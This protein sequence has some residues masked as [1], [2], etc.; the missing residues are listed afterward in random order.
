MDHQDATAALNEEFLFSGRNADRPLYLSL[1]NEARERVGLALHVDPDL[2]EAEI[3]RSV[4]KG[5]RHV[6]DP[7]ENLARDAF[8]DEAGSGERPPSYT[9][10][11]FAQCH[12]AALMAGDGDYGSSNYYDRLAQALDFPADRLRFHG[13]SM[14]SFWGMFNAWLARNDYEFGRPTARPFNSNKYINYAQTQAIIRAGDRQNFHDMFER[15]G[16]SGPDEIEAHELHQYVQGWIR[17]SASND[18]L[19]AAWGVPELRDRFC[20]IVRAELGEWARGRPDK[21]T[22]V[23]AS[24]RLS[25]VAEIVR[26]FPRPV[27]RLRI[28]RPG[29]AE[30]LQLRSELAAGGAAYEGVLSNDIYGGFTTLSPSPFASVPGLLEAGL[31]LVRQGNADGGLVWRPRLL[32]P[33][34]RSADGPYWAEVSR[35]ALGQPHMV[36]AK[37]KRSLLDKVNAHLA[38]TSTGEARV[39]TG[40]NL[41]GV[42]T[43][44]VLYDNVTV[45]KP[46][47]GE[48]DADL[49]PLVP[50]GEEAGISVTGGLRLSRGIWHTHAPPMISYYRGDAPSALL[51][52]RM[53]YG[54]GEGELLLSAAKDGP[55]VSLAGPRLRDQGDGEYL[56]RIDPPRKGAGDVSI[57]LRSAERPRALDRQGRDRVVHASIPTARCLEDDEAARIVEGAV[58]RFDPAVDLT[59]FLARSEAGFPPLGEVDDSRGREPELAANVGEGTTCVARGYHV[60]WCETLPPGL[61][62]STP[63]EMRCTGCEL[64]VLTKKRGQKSRNEPRNSHPVVVHKWKPKE[65][66]LEGAIDH[67]TLLDALCFLGAGPI[68]RVESLLAGA[69]DEA[70]RV[71]S[72]I[73]SYSALGFVD[74]ELDP[75]T[76]RAARFC[77]PPPAASMVSEASAVLSGFRSTSMI[78]RVRALVAPAGG[79]LTVEEAFDQ[80]RIVGITGL[81]YQ[82]LADTLADVT[83][84]LGRPI[85][86]VRD[87]SENL[88]KACVELGG[89]GD[90]M[91]EGSFPLA[92]AYEVF[93]CAAARWG[94]CDDSTRVGGYRSKKWGARYFFRS[95]GG[96]AYMGPNQVV[97]LLA[98]RTQRTRLHTYDIQTRDFLSTLG[99]EPIGLLARALVSA[100]GRLPEH[101][102]GVIAYGSVS[103]SVA[104][105]VLHAMYEA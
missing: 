5:L 96:G 28:G 9:A 80:P 52:E 93:D 67:D 100:T 73:A 105:A 76:G 29:E 20:E 17:T 40:D 78:E 90:C 62:R 10:L 14:A 2:V 49:A 30:P 19:R 56:V 22:G 25:L 41:P 88:A 83:D 38:A 66:S 94:A 97:K 42:P 84:G 18:R 63:L 16:F 101:R 4:G 75:T 86:I 12:A 15:F 57:I 32:V 6:G 54:A 13:K 82:R 37:A 34:A 65:P 51:L 7:F 61:P 79:S 91:A 104:G 95:P 8:L 44:W 21:P 89:L 1:D 24:L 103:Q 72:V 27:L 53:D 48:D 11:L 64:E 99:A 81:G 71:H 45:L 92:G 98:A 39:A 3:A 46:G 85:T 33:L 43:G 26:Q 102:G 68:S 77:V 31:S 59:A 36:L 58:C 70:W 60:W 47:E 55:A 74:V 35:I 69:V 50:L 23:R 87:A